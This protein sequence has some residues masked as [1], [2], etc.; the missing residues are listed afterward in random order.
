M[1]Y[2]LRVWGARL[3]PPSELGEIAA[4]AGLQLSQSEPGPTRTVV[5]GARARYSFTVAEG[6]RL[7]RDDVP[8]EITALMLDATTLYEV[9]VEGSASV[10]IPHAIRF[11]RRLAAAVGGVVEDP[12][13]GSFW[14]RGALRSVEAVQP[15]AA[16]LV[17]LSWYAPEG[18]VVGAADVWLASARRWLPEALPRRFGITE[19]L[20]GRLDRDGDQG[21]IKVHAAEDVM[22]H[23]VGGA[24]CAEG[25]L[26]GG[27]RT[28]GEVAAYKLDVDA[29]AFE[30]PRWRRAVREFFVGFAERID[31]FA[32][33]AELR[34]P[35]VFFAHL[36]PQGKWM[37]LPPYPASWAWLGS[38]YLEMIGDDLDPSRTMSVGAGRL[39]TL[40]ET[41][42][43]HETLPAHSWVPAEYQAVDLTS[44]GPSP[45]R[46]MS[47]GP[48]A[49]MPA[50]LRPDQLERRILAIALAPDAAG[51]RAP[52]PIDTA[53]YAQIQMP[54]GVDFAYL[55]PARARETFAFLMDQKETRRA[56]LLRLLRD[57]G[58]QTSTNEDLV[59]SVDAILATYPSFIAGTETLAEKWTS[60]AIDAGLLAGDLMIE[61]HPH[62]RWQL[63]AYGRK[64]WG[65][66]NA[67]IAGMRNI[68]NHSFEVHPVAST[69]ASA[70]HTAEADPRP[71]ELNRALR[72]MS[73]M[74]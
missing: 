41:P 45:Q 57:N 50:E 52:R 55:T 42:S 10:E 12:Q 4:G 46:S 26:S 53:D 70:H 48:A 60:V 65:Y 58:F 47:L 24:P 37:G 22:V 29:V 51:V 19:P 27:R 20:Q 67:A 2:D 40:S 69:L 44:S 36:S 33:T 32:A 17:E 5:R 16:D 15:K 66:G 56:E 39:L 63:S 71:G 8:D 74:A 9:G 11:A 59:D 64:T 25:Y 3:A 31:A 28:Y 68:P 34:A 21:F 62:L 30:D 7:E 1:S 35:G 38:R 73:K 72:W 54:H 23:F 43:P 13:A 14:T 18:S 49:S 61:Q 6:Q